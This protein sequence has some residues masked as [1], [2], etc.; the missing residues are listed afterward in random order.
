V[1]LDLTQHFGLYFENVEAEL[2]E[3]EYMSKYSEFYSNKLSV[4]KSAQLIG[5]DTQL[6]IFYKRKYSMSV[7]SMQ[8]VHSI[9]LQF[10]KL[11]TAHDLTDT[12]EI[13]DNTV[14]YALQIPSED[15]KQSAWLEDHIPIHHYFSLFKEQKFVELKARARSVE[16]E[17][18]DG[19]NLVIDVDQEATS[20]IVIDILSTNMPSVLPVNEEYS[21]Y[22]SIGSAINGERT[23][24]S[25]NEKKFNLQRRTSKPLIILFGGKNFLADVDY[26]IP[27]CKCM[28]PIWLSFGITPKSEQEYSLQCNSP[29]NQ[30][31]LFIFNKF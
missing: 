23:L 20:N 26:N 25:S 12:T 30:S 10:V 9:I 19:T 24:W 29:C 22:S 14:Q 11:A 27:I 8:S 15:E 31:F 4:K 7:N 6:L 13:R 3:M 5:T 18:F 28:M 1:N 17:I 2:D 21:L 16:L